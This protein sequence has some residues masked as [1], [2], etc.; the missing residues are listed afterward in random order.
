MGTE[1]MLETIKR[2]IMA[3]DMLAPGE[4]VLVALSGG[5]DSVA[6]L[7]VMRE[8]NYPVRAFHLNH[9]LR[10]AEADRDEKFC[11][12]LCARLGVALTVERADV[13]AAARE[14]GRGVEETARRIRYER[15]QEA[16]RGKKIA[17][18]H[19][20]DD[21]LE[22][23][24]FH[25]VRGT[26]P[27]GLAGIPPVRGQI[28]R[29]LLDVERVQI[30]A[31][32]AEIGQDYVTDSSN[33][34]EIYTRN[35][36]RHTVVP[37]LR[38]IQPA[39]AQSARRLG[40]LLR[41]DEACLDSLAQECLVQAE[42]PDGAWD[43]APLERAHPAVRTRALRSWLAQQGMPL[44]DLTQ[45]HIQALDAL[46]ENENPSACCDLPHGFAVRREYGAIR[47][48]SGV[49]TSV[50]LP[51][52]P[53][54]VPFEGMVWDGRVRLSLRHLEKNEVFYKTFNTFCVDCGTIDFASLCVRTRCAG[55]RIRLTAHGGSRTLKKLLIDRKVPRFRRDLLAVIADKYGVIAVQDIGMDD[56]RLPQGGARMQ[57]KIEGY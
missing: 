12:S 37:A 40:E 10:G 32:L 50:E 44:R 33:A 14:Q 25:L 27:K 43:I 8:L 45:R 15:L 54:S 56:A 42:R 1:A 18:A 6:L 5:A 9:W 39:A 7:L 19:T 28:I 55:D 47:L 24:L 49:E 31:Y 3:H 23:V 21:N 34:D 36:L 35:R 52:I 51:E 13:A 41:Q 29:P 4:P 22:T 57:I 11:R 38:A 46:L 48:L 30:E 2:T 16:A 26:G 53:L 20:A 17:T